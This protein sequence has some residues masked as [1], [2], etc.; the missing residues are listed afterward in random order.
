MLLLE[1]DYSMNSFG[2]M[3][4]DKLRSL[5]FILLQQRVLWNFV[6]II[7]ALPS[8]NHNNQILEL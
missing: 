6:Y 4:L 7:W 8:Y 1:V 5:V 3:Q 2:T